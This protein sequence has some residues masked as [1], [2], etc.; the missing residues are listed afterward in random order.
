MKSMVVVTL[1]G[2]LSTPALADPRADAAESAAWKK[3]NYGESYGLR[4]RQATRPK[5]EVEPVVVIKSLTESPMAD[6]VRNRIGDVEVCW[7]KLPAKRRVASSATVHLVIEGGMVTDARVDGKLPAG[8][9]ECIAAATSHWAFPFVDGR[10]ELE[11]AITF[12]AR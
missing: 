1:L 6:T 8:V 10:S 12:T 11:H 2:L 5:G 4:E 7:L 3:L 9:A